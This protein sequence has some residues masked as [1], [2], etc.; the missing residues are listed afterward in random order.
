ML[1]P[2]FPIHWGPQNAVTPQLGYGPQPMPGNL[3]TASSSSGPHGS[4][5]AQSSAN[6]FNVYQAYPNGVPP[7][8]APYGTIPFPDA[9]DDDDITDESGSDSSDD[10]QWAMEES[11][12]PT[13]DD[14]VGW[15]RE[16]GLPCDSNPTPLQA[17]QV[18]REAYFRMRRARRFLP[19]S[20][21]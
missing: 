8:P 13:P 16:L 15:A 19:Q 18:I 9:D 17:D 12:D 6:A 4:T 7:P 5:G 10:N 20:H 11:V 14:I 21:W 3:A 2:S 1:A